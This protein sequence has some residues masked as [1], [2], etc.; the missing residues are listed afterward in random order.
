MSRGCMVTILRPKRNPLSGSPPN[1]PQNQKKNDVKTNVFSASVYWLWTAAASN[2]LCCN[3]HGL[4]TSKVEILMMVD[5][6][7]IIREA[8]LPPVTALTNVTDF[9]SIFWS[10]SYIFSNCSCS[11][12][13][14]CSCT[15]FS[16]CWTCC[17]TSPGISFRSSVT[18]CCILKPSAVLKV[19]AARY[20]SVVALEAYCSAL[21]LSST[22]CLLALAVRLAKGGLLK[23]ASPKS[24]LIGPMFTWFP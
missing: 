20:Y 24:A 6:P 12:R 9:L 17:C 5:S 19:N 11:R 7:I 18:C 1:T 21:S 2:Y 16:C 23:S 14:C 10:C 8:S 22:C 4:V 15:F 13:I 3:S